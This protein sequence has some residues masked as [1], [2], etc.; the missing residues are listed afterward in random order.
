LVFLLSDFWGEFE[1]FPGKFKFWKFLF[2]YQNF[3]IFGFFKL[4]FQKNPPKPHQ[5]RK[6]NKN[7]KKAKKPCKS[8]ASSNPTKNPH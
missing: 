3:D 6:F 4:I 5:K 1:G 7:T 8:K 2:F